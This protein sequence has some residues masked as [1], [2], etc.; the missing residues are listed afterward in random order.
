MLIYKLV[1]FIITILKITRVF[2]YKIQVKY[3]LLWHEY[4]TNCKYN[5][6]FMKYLLN[7]IYTIY[8]HVIIIIFPVTFLI[9]YHYLAYEVFVILNLY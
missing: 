3:I 1:S 2:L 6:N 8:H 5:I 9:H 4:L 7:N